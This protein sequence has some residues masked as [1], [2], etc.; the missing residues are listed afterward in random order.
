MGRLFLRLQ[1]CPTDL[2]QPFGHANGQ[3][4][5]ED[6]YEG[7]RILS[8]SSRSDMPADVVEALPQWT[9]RDSQILLPLTVRRVTFEFLAQALRLPEIYL[10]TLERRTPVYETFVP[11]EEETDEEVGPGQLSNTV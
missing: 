1:P 5:G 3:F 9:E 4:E 6:P 2:L 8:I 10:P 11:E 7:L